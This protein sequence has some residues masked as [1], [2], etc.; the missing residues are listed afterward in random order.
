MT[1]QSPSMQ[2]WQAN[3]Y[4]TWAVL[5]EIIAALKIDDKIRWDIVDEFAQSKCNDQMG[6][7]IQETIRNIK[8]AVS[9]AK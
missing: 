3:A 6:P 7:F 4:V 1:N 5:G 8:E 9:G 2:T